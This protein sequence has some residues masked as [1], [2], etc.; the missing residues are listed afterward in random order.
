MSDEIVRLHGINC[1]VTDCL[2]CG[3]VFVVPSI[4]YQN[5]RTIGGYHYCP[6]GHNQGWDKNGS[7]LGRLRRERDWLA[8]QIAQRDDE[9]RD[10][11]TQ[12]AAAEDALKREQKAR[13]RMEKRVQN[14]VCPD[15][16]RSFSNLA[17][18]MASKHKPTCEVVKLATVR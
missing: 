7:E 9:A 14:G 5:Q 15:C 16:N 3:V 8:Q 4:V 1:T 13:Q 6:N 10:L 18:H 11:R 12:W 17:R 2:S